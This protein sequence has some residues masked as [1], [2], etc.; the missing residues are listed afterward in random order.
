MPAVQG[1]NRKPKY[2]N[3]NVLTPSTLDLH[4]VVQGQPLK[5]RRTGITTLDGI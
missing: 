3:K 1:L 4:K 5:K 2:K